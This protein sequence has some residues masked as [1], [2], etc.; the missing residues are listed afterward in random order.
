MMYR[1]AGLDLLKRAGDDDELAAAAGKL[2][3]QI[4]KIAD[5]DRIVTGLAL[6]RCVAG[7]W[8]RWTLDNGD[9]PAVARF[10]VFEQSIASG[11]LAEQLVEQ[12][13]ER[14]RCRRPNVDGV[15]HA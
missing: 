11:E 3:M 2:A 7:F 12:E 9:D 15:G 4:M 14:R 6:A 5:N 8:A 10:A 1:A 13:L